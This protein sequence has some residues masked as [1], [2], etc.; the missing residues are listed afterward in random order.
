[1]NKAS[2]VPVRPHRPKALNRITFR[3]R[4]SEMEASR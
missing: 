3:C 1:L 2:D 4:T